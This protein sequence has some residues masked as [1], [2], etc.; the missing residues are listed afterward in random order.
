M[1]GGVEAGVRV[2]A[3]SAFFSQAASPCLPRTLGSAT[4]NRIDWASK[5]TKKPL[6]VGY[7]LTEQGCF[8]IGHPVTYTCRRL[9]GVLGQAPPNL[10][11]SYHAKLRGLR[12]TSHNPTVFFFCCHSNCPLPTLELSIVRPPSN[13]IL[14]KCSMCIFVSSGTMNFWTNLQ[15]CCTCN[16]P[17]WQGTK[18]RRLGPHFSYGAT[19]TTPSSFVLR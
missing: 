10:D 1:L 12:Y 9:F 16:S 19:A 6:Q 18:P 13:T 7:S 2:Q 8:D 11:S 4:Q 3:T 14:P 17:T 15:H 5:A